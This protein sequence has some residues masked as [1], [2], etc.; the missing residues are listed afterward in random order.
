MTI[1]T[2]GFKLYLGKSRFWT[3]KRRIKAFRFYTS[4]FGVDAVRSF[5][6]D[7]S[8]S[9]SGFNYQ[10]DSMNIGYD[11]DWSGICNCKPVAYPAVFRH[12]GTDCNHEIFYQ[13]I[14]RYNE[15]IPTKTLIS[16]TMTGQD[17]TI[18]GIKNGANI[19]SWKMVVLV[20]ILELQTVLP[21]QAM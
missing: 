7:N 4:F 3:W 6:D 12:I 16:M 20:A 18:T 17:L 21:S 8:L 5:E 1:V 19:S 9:C 10:I 13:L 2:G 11:Y 14:H 15:C